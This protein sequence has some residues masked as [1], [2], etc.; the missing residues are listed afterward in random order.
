MSD[1][2]LLARS[3]LG[4]SESSVAAQRA[5]YRERAPATPF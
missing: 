2:A 3:P 5:V 4:I 1:H